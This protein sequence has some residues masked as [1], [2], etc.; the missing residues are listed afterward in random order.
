MLLSFTENT[1]KGINQTNTQETLEFK[2]KKKEMKL[3]SKETFSVNTP[4]KIEGDRLIGLTR[5]DVMNFF[6]ATIESDNLKNYGIKIDETINMTTCI[7]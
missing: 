4:L 2:L 7:F 5:L 1:K 3:K 6:D